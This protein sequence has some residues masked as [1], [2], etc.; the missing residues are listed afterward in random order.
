LTID[1]HDQGPDAL[2]TAETDIK[3]LIGGAI[4]PLL[5]QTMRKLRAEIDDG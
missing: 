4:S 1:G 3:S 2:L 5:R